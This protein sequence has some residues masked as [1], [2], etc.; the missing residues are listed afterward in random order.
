[1]LCDAS[2]AVGKTPIDFKQWGITYLTIS[3][4]KLYA[5]KGIGALVIKKDSPLEPIIY[6]GGHEQGLRSGTLNVP[7]IVGL[8]E[9][10]RLR[11]LEMVEDESAI[12]QKRDRLQNLL[13]DQIPDL[14]INGDLNSRLSG[15]LHLAI[16][17]IPNSAVVARIHDQLAISTGAACSSGVETPSHVLRAI[18]LSEEAIEGAL[19]IGIGK[20]TTNDEIEQASQILSEAILNIQDLIDVSI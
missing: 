6:G 20:F 16:P 7:G 2:Q 11:Q 3:G 4:H 5:P 13:L 9:A 1:M 8:G 15:N 17:G 14:M 10:C 18:N 12:A 19:R